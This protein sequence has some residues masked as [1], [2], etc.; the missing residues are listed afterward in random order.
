[1]EKVYLDYVSVMR[2][3][4]GY[5]YAYVLVDDAQSYRKNEDFDNYDNH[6]AC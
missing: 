4:V 5:A 2:E 6:E 1:M 3:M